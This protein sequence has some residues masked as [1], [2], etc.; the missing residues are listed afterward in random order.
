MKTRWRSIKQVKPGTIPDSIRNV[1]LDT[2]SLTELLEQYCNNEFNLEL[3][4]QS[5]QRPLLEEAGLLH[6]PGGRHALVRE[7][8][9]KCGNKRLVYGRSII[10]A[11]TFTGAE[12]RL[13]FLGKRSLGNYLFTQRKAKRG[14]MEI[15]RIK[16][17]N[18][19]FKLAHQDIVPKKG[20]DLW[21]RRSM[22]FIK[23]KPLL[24]V[25][26]FLPDSIKCV[27]T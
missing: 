13:A 15:G 20:T 8:Y 24:V 19:L 23:E 6:L 14:N 18:H 5:W 16:S 10:P 1:L 7:I 21:G 27:N 12:R 26:I 4:S 11:S 25:E 17:G 2:G 3:K 9:L 22:F